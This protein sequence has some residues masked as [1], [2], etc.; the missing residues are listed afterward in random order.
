MCDCVQVHLNIG[1]S[2]LC[3]KCVYKWM[4]ESER[5]LLKLR[6]ERKKSFEFKNGKPN[7]HF[8]KS[9]HVDLFMSISV[10]YSVYTVFMSLFNLVF[11][12]YSLLNLH[13][14]SL[15]MTSMFKK[16]SYSH[17]FPKL[18]FQKHHWLILNEK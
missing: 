12:F 15:Q 5:L 16:K 18:T 13:F 17:F 1:S 4:V 11:I 2:F 6:C 14:H 10:L 8:M 3:F 9:V 7:V